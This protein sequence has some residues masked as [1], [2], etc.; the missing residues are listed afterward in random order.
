[1]SKR[2]V[3]ELTEAIGRATDGIWLSEPDEIRRL[4][5]G[6]MPS[7]AGTYGNAFANLVFCNGDLRALSTWITPNLML[8]ALAAPDFTL[9]QC[10]RIFAW[11]NLINVDFLAYCGFVQ[12]GEFAH[13]I[14]DSY[15]NIQ[16]KDD[17]LRVLKAWYAYSAR[18]YMWL[19]HTFPWAAGGVFP[20]LQESE[21]V[22]VSKLGGYGSKIQAYFTKH[23]ERLLLWKTKA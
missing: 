5:Y 21:L 13:D 23:R 2:T 3:D 12:L 8:K 6:L 18:M 11:I 9:E 22:D 15:D 1:M 10:K 14:V 16:S 19:H 7:G 17:F 20:R 4:R